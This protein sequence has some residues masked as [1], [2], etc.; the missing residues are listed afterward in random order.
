MYT[1]KLL[2]PITTSKSTS[3]YFRSQNALL[4]PI[5]HCP[6]CFRYSYHIAYMIFIS[7]NI[8][9]ILFTSRYHSTISQTSLLPVYPISTLTAVMSNPPWPHR[10]AQP[11]NCFI[12]TFLLMDYISETIIVKIFSSHWPIQNKNNKYTSVLSSTH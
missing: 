11:H 2:K 8:C 6:L 9:T 5:I 7:F 1:H 12:R 4:C 10:P 3:A